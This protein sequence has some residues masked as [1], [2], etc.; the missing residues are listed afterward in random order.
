MAKR[1][2]GPISKRIRII[3]RRFR[4]NK[5][6]DEEFKEEIR[7]ILFEYGPT[8]YILQDIGLAV[9]KW[10]QNWDDHEIEEIWNLLDE[11]DE[12]IKEKYETWIKK[13]M[14]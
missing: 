7:R 2:R 5:I 6:S 9:S 8:G 1:K 3:C 10:T 13:M 11:V 14:K 12:K 4:E